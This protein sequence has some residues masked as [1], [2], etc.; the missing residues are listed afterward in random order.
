MAHEVQL[1]AVDVEALEALADDAGDEGAVAGVGVVE[2]GADAVLDGAL[3]EA[4]PGAGDEAVRVAAPVVAVPRVAGVDD[5]V[6]VHAHPRKEGDAPF[7]AEAQEG[8]QGP[9]HSSIRERTL[10][11]TFG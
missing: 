5:V 9:P 2:A 8:R 10:A 6:A 3:G 4:L 1:D 7:P 11:A